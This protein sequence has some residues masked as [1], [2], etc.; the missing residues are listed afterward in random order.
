MSRPASDT[1]DMPELPTATAGR[2]DAAKAANRAAIIAAAGATFVELGY[3]A[4]TVRD[5]V[6]RT[7]LAAGTFYNYFP[8]KEAVLRAIVEEAATEARRRVRAARRRARTLQEFLADGFR[9]YYEFLA[10]DPATFHLVRRNAGTIRALFDSPALGAGVDE[11]AE[12]LRAGIAAGL[13]PHMD[14]EYAARA[15]IGAAFEVGVLMLERDPPDIEGAARF[16]TEL[17]AGGIE[18]L[19]SG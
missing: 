8:D 9:A 7:D 1:L 13:L 16:V 11:L 4:A 5:I 3:G 17:F 19:R 2:R 15:I 10:E 12:D 6:R 18:R 14:V